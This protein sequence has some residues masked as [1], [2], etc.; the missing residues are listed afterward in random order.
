[1]LGAGGLASHDTRRWQSDPD[2]GV[3]IEALH[4]ILAYM[5]DEGLRMYRISSDFVPYATH[6]DMPR[7]HGQIRE[8]AK[9]L[10]AVGAVASGLGIRLSLHPSQYVLLNAQD[11]E[12]ARNSMRDLESQAELLD[13]MRQGPEAVVVLHVGGV[14]GDRESA[15]ERFVTR[16]RRLG[17]PARRRLVVENDEM[18]FTVEDCLRIHERIGVPIVFDHQHHRLN[19]GTLGVETA[20]RA[21]L[22]SWPGTVVPKIHFSSARLD[23]RTVKRG[24]AV[25]LLPPLL[26]QHADYVDPWT[27]AELLGALADVRFDVML[28]AKA[29]DLALKK[30]LGDLDRI[31]RVEVLSAPDDPPGEQAG[32]GRTPTTRSGNAQPGTAQPDA[33]QP[34][35][36]FGT[37]G[38]HG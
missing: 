24:K 21:A 13:A 17:E 8:Y 35:D 36:G 16:Y 12:I 31:G 27:F 14:Y 22:A 28:E 4:R 25:K 30:L 1:V 33:D 10:E 11:D 32:S 2:L 37:Q 18:S 26:R 15:L 20:A 23:A 19:P 6:P 29:K 7:F 5:R 34:G 9:E 38:G 3:S